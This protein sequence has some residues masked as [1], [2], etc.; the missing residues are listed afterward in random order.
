MPSV[1][2]APVPTAKRV[3]QDKVYDYAA[4]LPQGSH[5]LRIDSDATVYPHNV[6]VC[7][8]CIGND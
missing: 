8:T 5:E 3:I 1:P 2:P 4:F 7:G 6:K